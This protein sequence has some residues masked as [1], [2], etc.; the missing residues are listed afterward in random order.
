MTEAH[1]LKVARCACGHRVKIEAHRDNMFILRCTN[2]RCKDE[3]AYPDD[4]PF[5]THESALTEVGDYVIF[6]AFKTR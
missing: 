4:H 6:E 1:E 5:F 3:T 2:G